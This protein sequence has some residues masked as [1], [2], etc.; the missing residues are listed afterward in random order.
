MGRDVYCTSPIRDMLK[1]L[2][3]R[4]WD[5]YKILNEHLPNYLQ[6]KLTCVKN[7]LGT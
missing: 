4:D 5:I 2:R 3:L 1:E 7:T 6:E